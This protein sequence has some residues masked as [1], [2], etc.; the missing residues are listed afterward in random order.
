MTARILVQPGTADEI[1]HWIEKP[2]VRIGSDPNSDVVIPNANVASQALTIEFRQTGYRVYNR[3]S[4]HVFLGGRLLEPNQHAEWSDVDLLELQEGISLALDVDGNPA[5]VATM[6]RHAAADLAAPFSPH[7]IWSESHVVAEDASDSKLKRPVHAEVSKLGQGSVSGNSKTVVQLA[8]S[9]LCLLGCAGL[10]LRHQAKGS[11][12]ATAD[13]PKFEE[14]VLQ[15]RQPNAAV[16]AD[17]LDQLQMAEAAVVRRQPDLARERYQRLY[18]RLVRI[19]GAAN[20]TDSGV[21]RSNAQAGMKNNTA[22]ALD[23]MQ[24]LVKHRLSHLD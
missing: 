6:G 2:V 13:V 11:S 9:L 7:E 18:D 21:E 14:V 24:R 23:S 10:I 20:S 12:V 17:M 1:T 4:G 16:G 19:A 5:P 22:E 3:S 15:S 8:I